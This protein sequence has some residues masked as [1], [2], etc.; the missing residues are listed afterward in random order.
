[1]TIQNQNSLLN[2]V[3][4]TLEKGSVLTMST[5]T[6]VVDVLEFTQISGNSYSYNIVNDLIPTEH[7]ELGQDVDAHDMKTE[8]KTIPLK[9]LT[10]SIAV[11]RALGVMQNITDIQAE[12]QQLAM[13]SSGKALEK[14]VLTRLD[15]ELTADTSGKK[16]TGALTI[17]LLDDA[18]DYVRGI[19]EG[20]GIIF[21]N[22]KTKRALTKL[23]KAEGYTQTTIDVFGR[24]VTEYDNVPIMVSHDMADNQIFV[25]KFGLDAVH[26]I[27]NGGLKCYNYDKGVFKITDTEMLY[28]IVCKTKTSFAKIEVTA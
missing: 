10:N 27:T 2:L 26:A 23:F 9:V 4:G 13:V 7:R 6:P 14:F 19:R 28:N 5:A 25:V 11:D 21:V 17:D 12:S 15:E 24:K 18:L 20:K 16:F 3:Q 1:M 8:K 22:H